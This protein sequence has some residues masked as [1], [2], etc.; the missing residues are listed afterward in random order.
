MPF[1]FRSGWPR[2]GG[3]VDLNLP[4]LSGES[5]IVHPQLSHPRVLSRKTALICIVILALLVLFFLSGEIYADEDRSTGHADE[6]QLCF[7]QFG[8]GQH[9][10]GILDDEPYSAFAGVLEM[11][12]DNVSQ[13]AFCMDIRAPLDQ[14][15]CYDRA[16][17]GVIEPKASCVLQYYPPT[18]LT[19][20]EDRP[21][22]AARQAA[23]WYFSDDFRLAIT[24]NVFSRY[25]TIVEDIETKFAE[26]KCT[27]ID[28]WQLT[29]DPVAT[30]HELVSDGAGGYLATEQNYTIQLRQGILPVADHDLTIETDQGILMWNGQTGQVLTVQTDS[31]GTAVVTLQNDG[32]IGKS[33]VDV[34]TKVHLPVG[35]R[36]DPGIDLQKVLIS[37]K[38]EHVLHQRVT[39][40]WLAGAHLVVKKFDDENLDGI[41]NNTDR[42]IDWDVRICE[43]GTDSCEVYSLGPDGT[44]TIAVDPDKAYDLCELFVTD[45]TAT[46]PICHFSVEP[47]TTV[48]FGNHALPALV[49]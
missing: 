39:A 6:V 27:P 7:D 36:I 19:T 8:Y 1:L 14:G 5:V 20:P 45:W 24:D 23:I 3:P 2:F 43:S 30:V 26:G 40:E 42:L 49:L 21:E 9:V 12:V 33:T 46:T 22:I 13:Q 17:I 25:Q 10:H 38:D 29:V 35:T 15:T 4:K 11:R 34:R 37:G 48:W 28:N 18:E 16:T 47:P 44:E 41:F 32:T 31:N